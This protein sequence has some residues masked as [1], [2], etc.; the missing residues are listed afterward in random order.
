MCCFIFN[1]T[2]IIFPSKLSSIFKYTILFLSVRI[3]FP[4][5]AELQFWTLNCYQHLTPIYKHKQDAFGGSVTI[6]RPIGEATCGGE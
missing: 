1:L 3:I 5:I 2:L 6:P 4:H